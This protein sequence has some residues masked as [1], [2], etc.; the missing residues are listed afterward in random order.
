MCSLFNKVA[1]L[2]DCNFIKDTQKAFE[3]F[4]KQAAEVYEVM[5]FDMKSIYIP[6]VYSIHYTF[7]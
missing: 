6:K 3:N 5:F 4:K 7:K 2:R 1:G